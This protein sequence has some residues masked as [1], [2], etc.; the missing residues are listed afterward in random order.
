[1]LS[2]FITRRSL[3]NIRQFSN[4]NFTIKDFK[5]NTWSVSGAPGQTVMKAGMAAGVPF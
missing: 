4:V 5:D 1:M 2:K 3:I